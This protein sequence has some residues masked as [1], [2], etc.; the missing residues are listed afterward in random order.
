VRAL[1][2]DMGGRVAMIGDAT[3]DGQIAT[4]VKCARDRAPDR[5][6]VQRGARAKL[7]VKPGEIP[8]GATLR[9]FA[10]EIVEPELARREIDATRAGAVSR[11]CDERDARADR[12]HG[13][14]RMS[15]TWSEKEEAYERSEDDR[16]RCRTTW[17][18]TRSASIP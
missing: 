11:S 17:S 10:L 9:R 5:A 12:R 4:A 2:K 14:P 13:R 15:A 1:G 16:R 6:R 8:T 18:S 7:G 3:Q